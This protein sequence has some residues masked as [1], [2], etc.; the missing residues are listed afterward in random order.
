MQTKSIMTY[1]SPIPCCR[2]RFARKKYGYNFKWYITVH[3][4]F[5]VTTDTLITLLHFSIKDY[6][7]TVRDYL[8]YESKIGGSLGFF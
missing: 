4:R 3:L 5:K 2:Q 7:D 6:V 8:Q 1:I